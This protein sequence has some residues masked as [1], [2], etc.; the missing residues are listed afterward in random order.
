MKKILFLIDSLQ[1]GGAEKS[2]LE[3][4]SSLKDF[5]PIVC[6]LFSD[7][8][9]LKEEFTKHN[10][11]VYELNLNRYSSNWIFSGITKY[12]TLVSSIRPDIVH[13]HL[14]K[15][16]LLARLVKLPKS[17]LLL[18]AFVNDS[19]SKERY[20]DQTFLRNIK[21][22]IIR[23]VD[24][25]TAKRVNYFT[26]ITSSIADSNAKALSIKRNK[27]ETIYRGRSLNRYKPEQPSVVDNYIFITVARLLKR[28]GYI[29]LLNAVSY[30]NTE[31]KDLKFICQIA[32]DGADASEIKLHAKNLD[33]KNVEF[34]GN[35][36]DI[37]NLLQQAHAFI[38][39]SHYEGQG[40]ALVEAMFSAK[41]IIVSDIPVFNEQIQNMDTGLFFKLKDHIDLANKMKW[42][43]ENHEQ[44]KIMGA[45]ARIYAV[46][47]FDINNIA[48]KY[49]VYY[50]KILQ[51]K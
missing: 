33:I 41:P 4:A 5:E 42:M 39:P 1:T 14:F 25:I 6:T 12:K 18:G 7:K 35:R 26:S 30:L 48:A 36:D 2:I 32:G 23:F 22:N 28:K 44:G 34:L 46:Q 13:A 31:H 19:Y 45:K 15:S 21:L 38:F 49:D 50:K 8:N 27:I 51:Y 11:V 17:S 40:G 9:D 16:E 24:R 29:D 47:N 37:P 43:I 10:I 20:A 3:I